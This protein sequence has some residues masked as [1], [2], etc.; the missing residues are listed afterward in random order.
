MYIADYFLYLTTGFIKHQYETS[1]ATKSDLK[2]PSA[3]TTFYG[4]GIV[5]SMAIKT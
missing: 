1:F 2:V 5:T 3:K 4:K